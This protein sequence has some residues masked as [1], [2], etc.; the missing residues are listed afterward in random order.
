MKTLLLSALVLG[1]LGFSTQ[2]NPKPS[3]DGEM[4]EWTG[5]LVDADCLAKSADQPCEVSDST[6]SFALKV[7]GGQ[8]TMI[9]P[10]GNRKIQSALAAKRHTSGPVTA[11]VKG[12]MSE[13]KIKVD[14]I[15]LD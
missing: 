13:E 10:S 12:S 15:T 8:T 3:Q 2:A 11:T 5:A 9:D 6:R 7:S 1:L 4:K 14:S